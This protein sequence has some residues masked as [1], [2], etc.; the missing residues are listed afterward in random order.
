[1]REFL[2]CYDYGT[3]GLW[4]WIEAE[5]ADAIH[6][7]FRDLTVFDKPPAWWDERGGPEPNHYRLGDRPDVALAQLRRHQPT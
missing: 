1:M 7:E 5:S 3:G 4:W 6:A 2:S